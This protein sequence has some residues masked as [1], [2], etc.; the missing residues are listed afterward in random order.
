MKKFSQLSTAA[1]M[2]AVN[3]N[4]TM[5]VPEEWNT[6]IL[7]NWKIK[8]ENL[9]FI[10]PEFHFEIQKSGTCECM[11][12][13]EGLDTDS[14]ICLNWILSGTN[15]Y[16]N[17]IANTFKTIH[18]NGVQDIENYLK[19]EIAF[20]IVWKSKSINIDESLLGL[21]ED[22]LESTIKIFTSG[23]CEKISSELS[24]ILFQYTDNDVII[25]ELEKLDFDIN[26]NINA[27]SEQFAN[28]IGR[29]FDIDA[30][31]DDVAY[32]GRLSF[33]EITLT[34]PE[35]SI[36]T[37][38]FISTPN[39]DVDSFDLTEFQLMELQEGKQIF[40]TD[41][42]FQQIDGTLSPV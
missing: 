9:G 42:D 18:A 36:Y 1:K 2:N 31:N 37:I 32:V 29:N 38:E 23:I 21:I 34:L 19:P 4:R 6:A 22:K 30:I 25:K 28:L 27:V 13:F 5:L 39:F 12:T 10:N 24:T 20:K 17:I 41:F 14:K 7:Y 8:L 35:K 15:Q 16:R 26:G 3:S 40:F 11:F 33:T